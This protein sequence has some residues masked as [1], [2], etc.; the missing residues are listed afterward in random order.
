MQLATIGYEGATLVDF[1][2]TLLEAGVEQ[3]VDVR[4]IA[5][6]RRPGFSKTALRTALSEVGIDYH[7]IRQLGDPKHGREAARAGQ[8]DLFRA[9]FSAHMDLPASQDALKNAIV[10]ANEKKSAL[11]C[12]ERDPKNCHRTIVAERMAK[13][14]SLN[15]RNLGVQPRR[16]QGVGNNVGSADRVAGAC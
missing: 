10:L 16:A 13:L 7:H 4:E 6:S 15:I 12:F 8:I 9:I 3:V 5:Q 1:I 14:G 11:V 2:S